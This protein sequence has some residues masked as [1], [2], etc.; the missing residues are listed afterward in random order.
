VGRAQR[1]GAA[2]SAS[3]TTGLAPIL[4]VCYAK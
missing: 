4:N 3:R 1:K 2:S